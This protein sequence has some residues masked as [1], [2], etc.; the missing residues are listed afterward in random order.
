MSGQQL[1]WAL[2]TVG[3]VA[4]LVYAVV[5]W[6]REGSER[7]YAGPEPAS[8]WSVTPVPV[9]VPD[10]GYKTPGEELAALSPEAIQAAPL[11]SLNR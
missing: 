3:V 6:A 4:Y 2:F 11:S 1:F 9:V 10:D 5:C 8:D 7:F